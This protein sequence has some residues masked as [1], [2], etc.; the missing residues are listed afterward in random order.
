ME[1]VIAVLLVVL[2]MVG[3]WD[4]SKWAF[5]VLPGGVTLAIIIALTLVNAGLLIW[6]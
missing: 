2:M 6:G 1:Y 5:E 3:L 4:V